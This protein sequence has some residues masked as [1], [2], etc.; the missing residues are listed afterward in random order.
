[1]RVVYRDK[2]VGCSAKT[3]HLSYE[4]NMGNKGDKGIIKKEEVID[5]N[6]RHVCDQ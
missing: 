1:M 3:S 6:G 2:I 4:S 5:E